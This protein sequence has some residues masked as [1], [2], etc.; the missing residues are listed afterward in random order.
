MFFGLFLEMNDNGLNLLANIA[1]G[2]CCTIVVGLMLSLVAPGLYQRIRTSPP[3]V[4]FLI[5]VWLAASL[6]YL[7]PL[8]L[9]IPLA[10]IPGCGKTLYRKVTS[11]YAPFGML[12]PAAMP[13]SWCSTNI[14]LDDVKCWYKLKERGNAVILATHT[15][16][17]DWLVGVYFFAH[18]CIYNNRPGFVA[19]ATT[20]LMPVIGWSR[21]LV[22]DIFLTRAFH[23]DS[24]RIESNIAEFHKSGIKR[25]LFIAPE[26][27]IADPKDPVGKQYIE[28][29]DLFMRQRGKE[30]LTHLL[31]PRYKGMQHFI[32]HAPDNVMSISMAYVTDHSKID[33]V[34]GAVVGGVN[35]TKPQRSPERQIADVVS[36]FKG[37]LG[38]YMAAR[39]VPV[40][41]AQIEEPEKM[42]DLMMQDQITKDDTLRYFDEHR[43]YP[44]IKTGSSWHLLATP[45][46][47][48]NGVF[49]LHTASTVAVWHYLFGLTL[50]ASIWRCINVV[51]FIYAIFGVT[52]VF[53]SYVMGQ[54][55]ESL[56][57]ETAVKATIGFIIKIKR[58]IFGSKK[59]KQE[60]SS[61]NPQD[62]Q[63][64]DVSDTF[65]DGTVRKRKVPSEAAGC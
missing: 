41:K 20:A 57:G 33:P 42:R 56:P 30:P 11:L 31:T 19:E 28:D 47:L 25:M 15:S 65:T 18:E 51:L 10:L 45:H 1:A 39:E 58:S 43:K 13:F 32:K 22:G 8:L 38:V 16:R 24:G 3:V 29:C 23:K 55:M 59:R 37:G 17:I 34:S 61:M 7:V 5:A 4:N 52:H 48:F 26:G 46:L 6:Q 62:P 9:L 40:S 44:L 35:N 49:L 64:G 60:P 2:T 14:Y 53:G 63:K 36:I 27:F 54:S 12:G 21:Y 50:E